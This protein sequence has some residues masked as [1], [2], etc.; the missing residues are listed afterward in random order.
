MI[1][2]IRKEQHLQ[3][4]RY[5]KGQFKIMKNTVINMSKKSSHIQTVNETVSSHEQEIST[6]NL[7]FQKAFQQVTHTKP[8]EE[9]TK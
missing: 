5:L 8:A 2:K 9:T 4:T 1:R 3:L 7:V 6:D